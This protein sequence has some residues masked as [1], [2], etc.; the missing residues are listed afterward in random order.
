MPMFPLY[1]SLS[2]GAIGTGYFYNPATDTSRTTTTV[3]APQARR[4]GRAIYNGSTKIVIWGGEIWDPNATD[5]MGGQGTYVLQNTGSVYDT[6]ANTW[7]TMIT[8]NAPT[9]RNYFTGYALGNEVF[10][11]GGYGSGTTES[12]TGGIYNPIK[13]VWYSLNYTGT[14]PP[15]PTPNSQ[16]S[17]W[18]GVSG[19]IGSG[20]AVWGTMDNSFGKD[21]YTYK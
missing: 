9:A 12:Y 21:G 17:A 19:M 4:G 20:Y 18:N 10:I 1:R 16:F 2:T 7:I 3:N 13:N 5:P 11:F 14:A 8:T 6:V 15:T